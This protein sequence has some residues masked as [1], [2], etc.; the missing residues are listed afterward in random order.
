MRRRDFLGVLGGAAAAW[1]VVAQA[2]QPVLPV[3]GFLSG[4]SLAYDSKLVAAFQQGL[5]EAGYVDGQNVVI[6]FRW[7]DGQFDLLTALAADLVARQVSVIFAGGVDVR[8]RLIK[9]AIS[10]IP[11]VFSTAGD[12]VDLG[13]V[14]SFNRPGGNATAVTVISAA[15]WPKRLELLLQMAGS[16]V[17]IALLVN[18]DDPSTESST[19]DVHTA[20]RG[21]GLQVRVLQASTENDFEKAF[22]ALVSQ[23]AG[24][25]LVTNNALFNNRREKLVALAARHAVPTIYDRRDYVANGGLMS[26]G[27]SIVDQYHQ[28]GLYVGR[29]LKG[30]KPADLPVVQ[31]TKFELVINLKT[32]KTLGIDVPARLLALTD[33]VIE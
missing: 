24:A 8:I 16:S 30:A 4:R 10:T 23:R 1:P 32:A 21:L 28:S 5:K 18:P 26:Y 20:A 17:T 14:A 12:P 3:V 22:A 19:R 33:E 15:L 25:L 29:I 13:L 11:V 31:P 2:Q 27:A 6:E 7:A 9:A